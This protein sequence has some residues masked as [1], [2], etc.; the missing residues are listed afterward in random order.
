MRENE[1]IFVEFRKNESKCFNCGEKY[2]KKSNR[3]LYCI[4]CGY[5]NLQRLWQKSYRKHKI[6]K[7]LAAT[8]WRKNHRE[9]YNT[10]MNNYYHTIVK[11]KKSR[12]NHNIT[13]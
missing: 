7:I 5:K 9:K 11:W 1:Y 2:I 4:K 12:P 6:E 8:E 13:Q 10:R 3:Q